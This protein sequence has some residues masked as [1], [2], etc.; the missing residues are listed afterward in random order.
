MANVNDLS[1]TKANMGISDGDP[2]KKKLKSQYNK[3]TGIVDENGK[4]DS[5]PSYLK[6]MK[7]MVSFAKN[8]RSDQSD[9]PSN[10]YPAQQ[11]QTS[12]VYNRKKPQTTA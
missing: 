2:K 4:T 11:A 5:N 9:N 1:N 8:N 3:Y 7:N 10:V 12:A 6:A